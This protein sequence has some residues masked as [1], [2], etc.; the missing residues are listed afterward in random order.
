MVT[1]SPDVVCCLFSLTCPSTNH[2][3]HLNRCSKSRSF[4]IN[5]PP[6]QG[7][8][9]TERLCDWIIQSRWLW[10]STADPGS[11]MYRLQMSQF[12]RKSTPI[13]FKFSSFGLPTTPISDVN[14]YTTLNWFS[15]ATGIPATLSINPISLSQ[16]TN[17]QTSSKIYA[18]RH[19]NYRPTG[20]TSCSD[21]TPL[22]TL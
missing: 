12:A 6:P 20:H 4:S 2:C 21:K 5:N 19:S 7:L 22:A 18:L 16:L 3:L 11:E 13:L 17:N 8:L 15:T 9:L 10:R 14:A 1:E